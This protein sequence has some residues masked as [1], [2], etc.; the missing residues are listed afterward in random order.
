MAVVVEWSPQARADLAEAW[1]YIALESVDAALRWVGYIEDAAAELAIFPD[2]G[3]PRDDIGQGIRSVPEAS[4][5]IFYRVHGERV[6]VMRVIH[7]ARNL[8][9]LRIE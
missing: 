4:Y 9:D 7:G 3:R 8:D 2:S 1:H 6:E 5:L